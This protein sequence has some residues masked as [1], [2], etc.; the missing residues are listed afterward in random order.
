MV[1]FNPQD[2]PRYPFSASDKSYYEVMTDGGCFKRVARTFTSGKNMR[3]QLRTHAPW[4]YG[5]KATAT[6]AVDP[7]EAQPCMGP[8]TLAP[9]YTVERSHN[10]YVGMHARIQRQRDENVEQNMDSGSVI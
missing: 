2:M 9:V 6:D 7:V 4:N 5:R 1:A 10:N 8:S 3:G